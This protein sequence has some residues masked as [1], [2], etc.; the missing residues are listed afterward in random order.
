MCVKN[1]IFAIKKH[2]ANTFVKC[3]IP[4]LTYFY[5][6]SRSIKED[7]GSGPRQTLTYKEQLLSVESKNGFLLL[8]LRD[9]LI[10]SIFDAM[11]TCL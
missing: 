9:A 5:K 10:N 8:L 6:S 11:Q 3:Q 2:K 1:V 7:Q 4:A